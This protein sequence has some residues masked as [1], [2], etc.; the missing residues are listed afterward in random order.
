ML[1]LFVGNIP[2]ACTEIELSEWFAQQGHDV[3]FAQVIRDRITGNS[4]G[5][6]FVELRDTSDLKETVERL[7]GQ[8]LSGRVL[9]VNAAT[10]KIPRAEGSYS[11]TV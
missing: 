10:P 2:N 8:R 5:F 4:R 1:R 3:A 6:G 7:H 9:T 11:Q